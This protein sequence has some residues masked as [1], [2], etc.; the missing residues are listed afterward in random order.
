MYSNVIII[1]IIFFFFFPRNHVCKYTIRNHQAVTFANRARPSSTRLDES[2]HTVPTP[3][4]V[5]LLSAARRLDFLAHITGGPFH[6]CTELQAIAFQLAWNKPFRNVVNP[7]LYFGYIHIYICMLYIYV[8]I[9]P[10]I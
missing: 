9:T 1:I 4:P 10:I 6:L 3:C 2:S 5:R 8:H 7:R